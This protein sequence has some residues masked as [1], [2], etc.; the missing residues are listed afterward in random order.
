MTTAPFGLCRR[1]ASG[2]C[3]MSFLT[4]AVTREERIWA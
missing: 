4:H 2:P 3:A 1:V